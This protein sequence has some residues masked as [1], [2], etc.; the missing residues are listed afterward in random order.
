MA[1]VL[2]VAKEARDG[3]CNLDHNARSE[4]RPWR[5]G[6]PHDGASVV[7]TTLPDMLVAHAEARLRQLGNPRGVTTQSC[8][9]WQAARRIAGLEAELEAVRRSVQSLRD[10]AKDKK[11]FRRG[12]VWA[13]REVEALLQNSPQN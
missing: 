11:R 2:A 7:S 12:T 13:W 10:I 1:G 8:I 6:W 3:C 4:F 9:E 5:D